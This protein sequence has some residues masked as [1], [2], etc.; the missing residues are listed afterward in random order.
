MS[1]LNTKLVMI[2]EKSSQNLD[3][4]QDGN[5]VVLEG[6]FAQFGVVNNNDRLYEEAEYLPHLEYLNKKISD[7]RLLGELDH[8]AQ[9]DISLSKVSH[10]IESLVYDKQNRQLKGKLRLLDTPSGRIAKNLVQAGVPISVSSRAAGIVESNKKVK[11]KKIFT[12]DL[13]ADPGFENAVL[14]KINESL[15]I[16]NE[17][18]AVYDMTD[19]YPDLLENTE[20]PSTE[21]SL[22]NENSKTNK[23]PAM[24]FVTTEEMN[25]YSL[26]VKEEFEKLQKTIETLNE[27]KEN[28]ELYTRVDEMSQNVEKMQKYLDYLAN[29]SDKSIQYSEYVAEKLDKVIEYT[30][31][32]SRTLDESID[33]TEHVA[34]KTDKNI[35]YSEYLKEQLEKGIAYSEYLKECLEKTVDYTE[36]V[37]EKTDH[38][39]QYSEYLAEKADQ[40]ISYSEHIAEKMDQAISYSEYLAEGLEKGIA[41]SEYL[42]EQSQAVA[43]YVEFS[44]NE[45]KNPESQTEILESETTQSKNVDYTSLPGKVD[46]LLESINKQKI[47]QSSE[48]H[49]GVMMLLDEKRRTEFRRMDETTKQKVLGALNESSVKTEEDATKVWE[50]VL[51]PHVEK[52]IE[53]APQEYKQLW[54]SLD[55]K[56]RQT[57]MAQSRTY[58]LETSYQIKN[59]W[60]TRPASVLSKSSAQKLNESNETGSLAP[61]TLG[62]SD[63]YIKMVG[64]LLGSKNRK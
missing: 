30:N 53:D 28:N 43:D 26:F 45:S 17:S 37:A 50:S 8:P 58:K 33:Y 24:E 27:S 6:I 64:D 63:E 35:Q 3:I 41:Y 2:L 62:Y 61:N 13:V 52:W 57:L 48:K 15:G 9:F 39:I 60:E 18:I 34:E 25:A 10:V 21:S 7:K 40:G 16:T 54:E 59:F 47:E 29:T 51:T 49:F 5:E 20:T 36:Y 19:K 42:A 32:I 14:T 38:N 56:S 44:V 22:E 1:D 55:D 46:Q 23:Q 11:I 31:Y 12:Y 4:S